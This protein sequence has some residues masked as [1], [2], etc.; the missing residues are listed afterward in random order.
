VPYPQPS[1]ISPLE[2][3][4]TLGN[5]F[6]RA[7]STHVAVEIAFQRFR[8]VA[9]RRL[10]IRGVSSASEIVDAMF[11]RGIHISESTANLVRRSELTVG[12]TTLTERAAIAFVRALNEATQAMDPANNATS[13][14]SVVNSDTIDKNVQERK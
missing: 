7:K 6:R 10:G 3:V 2:F 4:E 1:R 8:Q 5:V 13:S 14:K 12:D 11:Q 9:S